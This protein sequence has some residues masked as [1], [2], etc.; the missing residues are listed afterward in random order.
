MCLR[1]LREEPLVGD[2][3]LVVGAHRVAHVGP[4][5][6]VGEH[7]EEVLQLLRGQ[8]TVPVLGDSGMGR[9]CS[10]LRFQ[11]QIHL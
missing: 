7:V 1:P 3:A 6:H 5:R 4:P 2:P 11:R 8:R 10:T 9:G